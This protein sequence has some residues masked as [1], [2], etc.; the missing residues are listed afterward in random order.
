MASLAS[1][2]IRHWPHAAA[3]GIDSGGRRAPQH[4]AFTATLSAVRLVVIATQMACHEWYG[5][6]CL[7]NA[8]WAGNALSLNSV[9]RRSV[10]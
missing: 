1:W 4:T 3:K 8:S 10:V 6:R 7:A 5:S 2:L 9:I